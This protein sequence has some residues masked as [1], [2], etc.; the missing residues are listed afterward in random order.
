MHY[1]M[2]H[3][4]ALLNINAHEG[5]VANMFYSMVLKEHRLV[6]INNNTYAISFSLYN[7]GSIKKKKKTF[8]C[9]PC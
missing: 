1:N 8:N 3:S 7:I 4:V 5:F 2:G 6:I 9:C